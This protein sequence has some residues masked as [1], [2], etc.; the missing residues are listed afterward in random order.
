MSAETAWQSLM[1]PLQMARWVLQE[2][3]HQSDAP[4]HTVLVCLCHQVAV[5]S[6]SCNMFHM[7]HELLSP[8]HGM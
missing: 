7:P 6:A 4:C 3:Q 1:S 5:D 8:L 2:P